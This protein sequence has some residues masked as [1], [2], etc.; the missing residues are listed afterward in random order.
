MKS[1]TASKASSPPNAEDVSL[2]RQEVIAA[3]QD[4]R[5]ASPDL[6]N[7]IESEAA[8]VARRASRLVRARLEE[9]WNH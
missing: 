9:Q 7:R 8:P 3:I 5:K 1:E 2:V 4:A 6:S